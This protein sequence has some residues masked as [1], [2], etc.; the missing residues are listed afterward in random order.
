MRNP[1]LL[2]AGA[3]YHVVARANR[4]EFILD[5]SEIK[6]LFLDVVRRAKRKYSFSVRNFCVMGNHFHLMIRPASGENLSRI[7]QWILSVFAAAF[8][9]IFG[10]VGHVWYDRF[11]SRIIASFRQ[12]LAT[13]L[14]IAVNPVRAHMV[15]TVSDY[16]F[17]GIRHIRDGD[18]SIL[19]PPTDELLLLWP[20]LLGRPTLP[21]S[22]ATEASPEGPEGQ[23]IGQA[24]QD[25]T[26][27]S[28]PTP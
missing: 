24:N 1:R 4:R 14:Y 21:C 11:K 6:E 8:N 18:F 17:C 20:A 28:A 15:D 27:P 10:Y 23:R 25:T 9:R 12:F 26:R 7:M 22:R 2:Q 16:P 19:D 3:E 5:S 13:F